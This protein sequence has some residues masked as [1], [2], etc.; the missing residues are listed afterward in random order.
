MRRGDRVAIVGAGI[1]GLA[2]AARLA[3]AGCAV[4]VLER[5]AKPGGKL[6]ALP[7]AAGPVDA[8]P[9]VLTLRSVFDALFAALGE[10]LEDHVELVP[11]EVLA[12]HF[13]PDGSRLD[14]HAD[15][16]A[17]RRAIQTFAGARAAREFAAFDRRA[18]RLFE[19][20]DAPV[21]QAQR[22]SLPAV[23]TRMARAPGLI[24]AMAPLSSLARL[25]QRSFSDPRLAQLFGRYATYVGGTPAHSP[26]LIA[27]IWHA[28]ASGV[29]TLRGG[30]HRLAIVL[31]GLA[32][33]R[34][35]VFHYGAHVA[36]IETRD[37]AASGVVLET[38]ERIAAEAVLFNGDPRALAMG[39]LGSEA[40][41]LAPQTRAA[42]R[43]LSA[44]VWAFAARAEGPE[45][46]HHNVFFRD[47]P[48]TEFA[49]L[50][51]GERAPRPTLYLCAMDRAEGD[52]PEGLERFEII[53]NAPPLTTGAPAEEPAQCRTRIFGTLA[54]FGLQLTP[55]PPD[56]ALTTPEGF[57]RL[58][59]HSEGA[60]YGQSP[61]G[62]MAAFR[63]PTARTALPGLYLAGGG[64]HPGAGLPMAALS[65]RHA[66]E[67]IL[68]DRTSRLPSRPTATPGGTST[69]SATTGR[70]PSASSAS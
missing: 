12:R 26:A 45:L 55:H 54:G 66:A 35:A 40:A 69:G 49:A 2:A 19:A 17:T 59:P 36:R 34:G 39:A 61:H 52:A 42:P 8:G 53:A 65:A 20:F 5:H 1:A 56:A 30:L 41:L 31:A 44:D 48:A 7:S 9:T 63:R 38:G 22:P 57:A 51:R 23:A 16:G 70:G 62:L 60:L 27:L 68:S 67:A 32:E 15:A 43:S 25:L 11:Q 50:A 29:W 10:R 46:A 37:G 64:T 14:L 18:R 28:E 6:R 21:M 24:P 4:T 13:W 47:D 58:F 3:Q 33:A